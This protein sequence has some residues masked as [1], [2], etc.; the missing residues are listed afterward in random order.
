MVKSPLLGKLVILLALS[1]LLTVTA[2]SGTE[3]TTQDDNDGD[4]ANGDEDLPQTDGDQNPGDFDI[5]VD[6][7]QDDEVEAEAEMEEEAEI[8][9]EAEPEPEPVEDL[10]FRINTL[11]MIEPL[12]VLQLGAQAF[13]ATA[14]LNEQIVS[15]IANYNLNL[16]LSPQTTDPL[17]FPYDMLMGAGER[18]GAEFTLSND[19]SYSFEVEAADTERRFQTAESTEITI[20]LGDTPDTI[21]VLRDADLRGTYSDTFD[22]LESGVLAGAISEAD[23]NTFVI[24]QNGAQIITLATAFY[25]LAVQPD[26]TFGDGSKGYSFIFTYTAETAQLQ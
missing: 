18:V 21:L 13:D 11:I 15:Q 12:M 24:Y 9:E 19:A 8:E 5:I 1:L 2:C 16:L 17:S 6:G 25:W 3:T 7:D 4:E 20:P 14:Y 22:G 23:A 10:A 26:Y